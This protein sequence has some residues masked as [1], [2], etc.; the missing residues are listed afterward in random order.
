MKLALAPLCAPLSHYVVTS[1]TAET[2]ASVAA[3]ASLVAPATGGSGDVYRGVALAKVGR[4]LVIEEL[5][6]EVAWFLLPA[7]GHVAAMLLLP[8][9]VGPPA[10][11]TAGLGR[12][13]HAA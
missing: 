1:A 12:R 13:R 4:F 8:L 7:G 5:L 9:S 11:I 6:G 10:T 3:R 2:G